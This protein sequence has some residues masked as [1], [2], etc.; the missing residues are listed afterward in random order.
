VPSRR[1]IRDFQL[2]DK[3][4]SGA[5]GIVIRARKITENS[6]TALKLIPIPK[7][8]KE[9]MEKTLDEARRLS[10]IA[11]HSSIIRCIDFWQDSFSPAEHKMFANA[12]KPKKDD[13]MSKFPENAKK[14][15]I[16]CIQMEL[17]KGNLRNWLKGR[18]DFSFF[19]NINIL[20]QIARGIDHLHK[21]QLIH[22]D[23]KPSNI[24]FDGKS[25]KLSDLG[26]AVNHTPGN[27]YHTG[28][29]GARVYLAPEQE[30]GEY[31]QSVDYYALGLILF[32]LFHP[33]AQI[34][35]GQAMIPLKYN[36]KLPEELMKKFPEVSVLISKLISYESKTRPNMEGMLE[37][38]KNWKCFEEMVPEIQYKGITKLCSSCDKSMIAFGVWY[39]CSVCKDFYLCDD[40]E[41]ISVLVHP[42]KHNFLRIINPE[43]FKDVSSQD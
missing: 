43:R 22:R 19:D 34:N 1:S 29:A 13:V 10:S 28:N 9:K 27:Y 41:E 12:V 23:L 20:L 5:F 37:Y 2:H 8:S 26:W 17:C 21:H 3:L 38:I 4:G 15:D 14:L 16:L 11:P 6:D 36:Q 33:P 39:K 18:K 31:G 24:L 25:V 7:D 35:V 40:C 32:E 30:F 42:A